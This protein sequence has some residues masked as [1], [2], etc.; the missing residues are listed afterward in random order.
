MDL[1]EQASLGNVDILKNSGVGTVTN[2]D[3]ITPLEI[4]AETLD[5]KEELSK[6]P[7]I[8]IKRRYPWTSLKNDKEVTLEK[9][10]RLVEIDRNPRMM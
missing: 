6:I 9:I 8:W 5:S 4:L 2:E 10:K 7:Y 1:F 3:G